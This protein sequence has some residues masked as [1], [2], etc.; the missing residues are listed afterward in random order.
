M[1]NMNIFFE[2]MSMIFE[3]LG[4]ITI[5]W[6]TPAPLRLFFGLLYSWKIPQKVLEKIFKNHDFF[7][8]ILW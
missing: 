1:N 7:I 4:A 6:T 5:T 8:I 2:S 3:E